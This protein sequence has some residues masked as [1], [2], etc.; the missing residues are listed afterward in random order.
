MARLGVVRTVPILLGIAAIFAPRLP[1]QECHGLRGARTAVIATAFVSGEALALSFHPANWFVGPTG[2]FRLN[3]VNGGGSPAAGQDFLLHVTASYQLSQGAALAWRWACASP[4]AA[5]WLGAATAF[6]AGLPKKVVD[7]FHPAGFEASK[8]LANAV[9]AALP[10]LHQQWPATR[11]VMLKAW[12]WPSAEFRARS[13][14][15]PQLLSDYAGQRYYLSV[16]PARL[17]A[18]RWWPRWL[19]VAVGHGATAWA[20]A[21]VRPLWYA[22]LDLEFRGLPIHAAW[23]PK[24]AAV[25]DQVHFPAPGLRL[26]GGRLAVGVF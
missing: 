20:T 6:A 25:L 11:V 7:G 23:W 10:A 3:W 5:A 24:V 15:E 16:N 12:Y 18:V 21:P 2:P 9:G 26:D 8:N 13:G 14:G 19:G 22:G 4:G 1:A 17:P